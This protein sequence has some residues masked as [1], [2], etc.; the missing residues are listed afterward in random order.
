MTTTIKTAA[1]NLLPLSLAHSAAATANGMTDA[2]FAASLILRNH[3][4]AIMADAKG[5]AAMAVLAN[6]ASALVALDRIALIVEVEHGCCAV[7]VSAI[8][9][10]V[11]EAS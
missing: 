4:K 2:Q 9:S 11:L 7:S 1:S 3:T 5:K 8:I 6:K 10:A